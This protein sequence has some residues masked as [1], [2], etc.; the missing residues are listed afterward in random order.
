MVWVV[1]YVL[2]CLFASHLVQTRQSAVY[3]C[4]PHMH[5]IIR[6]AACFTPRSKPRSLLRRGAREQ[7][8][9]LT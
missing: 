9:T 2:G 6:P 4:W 8:K 7:L 3:T 1:A 5:E